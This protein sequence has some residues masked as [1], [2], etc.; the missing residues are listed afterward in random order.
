MFIICVVSF[1]KYDI[2]NFKAKK[3][4]NN[5]EKPNRKS[6]KIR[7]ITGKEEAKKLTNRSISI[8]QIKQSFINEK[9]ITTYFMKTH[10]ANTLQVFQML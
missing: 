6:Y 8:Q 3:Y 9:I 2:D 10:D 7:G 4:P 5:K 1:R